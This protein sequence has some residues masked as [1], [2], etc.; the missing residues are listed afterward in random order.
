MS[1]SVYEST[2]A[3]TSRRWL[4]RGGAVAAGAVML[5]AAAPTT[6]QAADSDP[7]NLGGDNEASTT[8][9]VPLTGA[10]AATSATVA[11]DNADGPTLSLQP[12]ASWETPRF[13]RWGRSRTR[14]W[15]R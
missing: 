9:R 13:W 4:L 3:E 2:P 7:A 6:A 8:T 11:L 15:V 1:D 14:S 12:S 5:A 10:A